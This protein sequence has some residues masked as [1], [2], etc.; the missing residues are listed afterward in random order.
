MAAE[1]PSRP[2]SFSLVFTSSTLRASDP[3]FRAE[4]EKALAPLHRD[5]RV[6]AIRTAYATSPPRA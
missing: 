6:L 3:R 1:L 5:P 2:S 4:A